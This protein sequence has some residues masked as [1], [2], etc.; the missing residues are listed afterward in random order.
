MFAIANR[1]LCF[2]A[3]VLLAVLL[4]AVPAVAETIPLLAQQTAPRTVQLTWTGTYGSVVVSRQYPDQPQYVDIG[5]TSDN[6]WT[7]RQHRSVCGDTV[8]YMVTNGT[9]TGYAAVFVSDN[10]P[11]APAQWGVVTMDHTTQQ[12]VLQWTASTDTDIMGY[13]VCEGTPSIAID[14]VFGR[15]NTLYAYPY[16]DSARVHQFRICAFD[17]CRQASALTSLCNN[18]VLYVESEP[19]GQN[20]T[21]T[22]NRYFN[23]PSEVGSYEVWVSE[24]D[25]PFLRRAQV[26]GEEATSATF[27]VAVGCTVMRSYVKA[28]SSDGA[29]TA[30]SNLVTVDFEAAARPQY[31]YLRRVSVDDGNTCVQVEGVTEPGWGSSDFKVYRRAGSSNP[32]VV[33]HCTPTPQ[34]ELYWQDCSAKYN[35]TVYTYLL[36]VT[37]ACGRNEMRSSPASTILPTVDAN[38]GITTISWNNYEGWEGTTTYCVY[39]SSTSQSQWQP[40]AVTATN[41]ITI[42]DN[43]PLGQSNY[44]VVAIEGPDSRY[45]HNDSVQSAIASYCPPTDIWMPNAFTPNESTNN[46]FGPHSLFINPEG[47]SFLIFNRHGVLLF[48][49]DD[50]AQAWDGRYRGQM[51][52]AGSY[53]YTITYRQSNGAERQLTGSFLIVN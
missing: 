27:T 45:K 1:R 5:A 39:R 32:T 34:G 14:T 2:Q 10:E 6:S 38:G 17:S 33:G 28:I 41:S 48:S 26:G 23:M 25:G 36:A 3:V 37:D 31:L 9:D 43:H 22:W 42:T 12:I 52:P 44:M 18:M 29:F 35:E 30:L 19:C 4:A 40:I 51:Q 8:R 46:T 11:T 24:N 20:V 13:L 16:E 21:A 53:V 49:T 50:P 47:Y 7:D 15:L